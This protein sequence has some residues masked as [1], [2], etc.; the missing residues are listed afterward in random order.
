V[1][2][3]DM[4]IEQVDFVSAYLCSELDETVYVEPPPGF[5]LK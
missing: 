5:E 2:F 1:A 3:F 4:E